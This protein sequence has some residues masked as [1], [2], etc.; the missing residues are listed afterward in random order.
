MTEGI[1]VS[2][3]LIQEVGASPSAVL[4]AR[5]VSKSFPGVRALAGVDFDI[6][7]GEVHALCGENGAGKS[8]LMRILSGSFRP[9]EGTVLL[10]DV[11]AQFR[12]TREARSNG[13]LLVHQEISLVPQLTV[14]ENIFLGNLPSGRGGTVSRRGLFQRA[15]DILVK[16]GGDFGKIDPRAKLGEL[17]FAVQQ[18]VEIARALAF[19]CSVVIFDEPTSSLTFS[20]TQSLFATIGRLKK[21]G[22]G[23]VYISHK[24]SEIFALSDRVTI[25]RDGQMRGTL[26]TAETNEEEVTRLMIGR[27][28]E[29]YFVRANTVIGDELLRVEG[30]VVRG[31]VKGLDFSVHKGE[32]LGLYGLIGAGRSEAMEAIFG[33]RQKSAGRLYWE[34]REIYIQSAADAVECGMAL[35]PED[36]KRQGLI[37]G[38]SC[39]ENMTIVLMRRAGMFRFEDSAAERGVFDR[40]KKL[41]DI[42]VPSPSTVANT[43]SG[44]NQQKVVL[45]KWLSTEPKL[46]VLDEPTRGIDVGAKAEIHNLVSKLAESGVSI[47]LISSELPEIL[48]LSTR[49]LTINAGRI[50]ASLDGKTA[51]EES[52]MTALVGRASQQA[53][54]QHSS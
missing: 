1:A 18:M 16:A 40:F 9:D 2:S 17:S 31:Y 33:V 35:V 5:Q 24:M 25:L 48:G 44:G 23:I 27:P 34:G 29:S 50:T 53:E 7:P 45:A 20:E 3:E 38:M 47:V 36:R 46:L 51:T 30:L 54:L 11:P 52:V 39:Q 6:R 15:K 21:S 26:R 42:K 28:L 22:V 19:N 8:T 13:I 41:L 49:I 12:N 43:L 10:N 4:G 14:A 37:L 32:V